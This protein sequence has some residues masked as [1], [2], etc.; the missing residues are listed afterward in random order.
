VTLPLLAR[1]YVGAKDLPSI[2]PR[3]RPPFRTKL[4]LAVELLGWASTMLGALG[5]RRWG[6]RQGPVPQAGQ[7]PGDHG[8][9]PAPQ[10]RGPVLR[11]G[12]PTLRT[13]GPA[14]NLRPGSD[15]PGMPPTGATARNQ[16]PRGGLPDTSAS[17]R[18]ASFCEKYNDGLISHEQE[19]S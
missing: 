14:A 2:D 1:L 6:V 5:G 19:L 12:C 10:G 8:R 3:H 16:P 11:P 18:G 4:E 15:R 9:Q 17:G 7:V 13:A